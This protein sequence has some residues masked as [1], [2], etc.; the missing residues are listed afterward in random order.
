[1][2]NVLMNYVVLAL[3]G[4]IRK[5]KVFTKKMLIA[6]TIG[7]CSSVI[8]V[9]SGIGRYA[10]LFLIL[11]VFV[12]STLL[13]VAF[14]KVSARETI[15]N[16]L[17]FYLLCS[18]VC[19]I[20]VYTSGIFGGSG[21]SMVQLLSVSILLMISGNKGIPLLL[22]KYRTMR[23]KY[24]VE[25][26]YHGKCVSGTGFLDTGNQLREPVSKKPVLVI[27]YN[28][29]SKLFSEEEIDFIKQYPMGIS[30]TQNILIHYIPFHSVGTEKGYLLGFKADSMKIEIE[31][32]C[33]VVPEP[34]LGI[35]NS[36]I[37]LK[38]EYEML[39]HE[40]FIG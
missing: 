3:L 6:A 37:S 2:V 28:L 34:W 18:L 24:P 5:R 29:V 10:F 15:L 14:G 23:Y 20:L 1:M 22:G 36:A 31:G 19:G 12:S 7:G 32:R 30:P 4:M 39:L 17:L 35:Y 21:I 40:E 27:D 25:I 11:Y 13:R 8:V 33:R 9:V 16:I 38:G 26:E